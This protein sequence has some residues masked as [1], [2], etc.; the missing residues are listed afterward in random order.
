[1]RGSG[2]CR[3]EWKPLSVLGV[4]PSKD[5]GSRRGVVVLPTGL[6]TRTRSG[7]R[8]GG[9][10]S[11]WGPLWARRPAEAGGLRRRV[12]RGSLRVA[13]CAEGPG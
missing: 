2:S 7:P 4:L 1:M 3:E 11:C 13:Q 12:P 10:G 8:E 9:L 5:L 6:G